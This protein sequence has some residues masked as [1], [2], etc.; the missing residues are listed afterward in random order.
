[1]FFRVRLGLF[2]F[3]FYGFKGVFRSFWESGLG[4]IRKSGFVLFRELFLVGV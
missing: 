4:F 3:K 2:I 1:M